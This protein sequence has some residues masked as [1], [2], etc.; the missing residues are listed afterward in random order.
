MLTISSLEN[1]F[2]S[3]K[4]SISKHTATKCDTNICQ[5][6]A[7]DRQESYSRKESR[8]TAIFVSTWLQLLAFSLTFRT[9]LKKETL[10]GI[11]YI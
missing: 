8:R 7:F 1:H 10:F 6:D 3:S 4:L 2:C 11:F 9:Y 5:N